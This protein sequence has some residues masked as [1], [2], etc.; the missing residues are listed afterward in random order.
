[1]TRLDE[2]RLE[3]IESWMSTL[4]EKLTAIF[5]NE[6]LLLGLQGSYQRG[7]A[8][9]KSD[10]DVVSIFERLDYRILKAF[11][12]V[13]DTM[14]QSGKACGFI[15]GRAELLNWP[16]Y[17]LFQFVQSTTIYLGRWDGLIPEIERGDVIQSVKIAASGLYH[18]AGHTFLHASDQGQAY[19]ILKGLYKGSFFVLQLLYYLRSGSY[20]NSKKDLSSLL[21]GLDR[22][23]LARSL[24]PA[25]SEANQDLGPLFEKIMIWTSGILQAD[26][27]RG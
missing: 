17:E 8:T 6:L 27:D 19:E 21:E 4:R 1:M 13:V 5:P 24:A 10:I 16:K 25:D 20:I 12:E 3:D 22:E 15:C 18:A 11:K 9:D 26:F 7:E 2:A 23:I 14:P